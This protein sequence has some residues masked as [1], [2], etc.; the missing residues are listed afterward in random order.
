M[1]FDIGLIDET[2]DPYY[3][4][5]QTGYSLTVE[6]PYGLVT[7]EI[8]PGYRQW[9]SVTVTAAAPADGKPLYFFLNGEHIGK[10]TPAFPPDSGLFQYRFSMPGAPVTIRI[11]TNPDDRG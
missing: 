1:G 7:G 10:F 4:N 5:M 6:D 2:M 3:E 8:A 9:E 11:T